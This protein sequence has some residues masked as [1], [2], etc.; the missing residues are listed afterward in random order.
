MIGKQG[1]T[2]KFKV[3]INEVI[4]WGFEEPDSGEN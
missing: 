1:L 3:Q 4:I 2:N